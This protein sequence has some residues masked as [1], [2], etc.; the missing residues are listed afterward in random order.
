M[1]YDYSILY[2]KGKE[3]IVAD[4][5]FKCPVPEIQLQTLTTITSNFLQK[6]Q[7]SYTGDSHLQKL[8]DQLQTDPFSNPLYMLH[9]GILYRKGKIMLGHDS[10]LKN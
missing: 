10:N 8:V 1:G 4:A 9:A 2:K 6:V 5:L 3:N 7:H